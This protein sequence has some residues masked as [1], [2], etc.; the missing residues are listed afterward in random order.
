MSFKYEVEPVWQRK[1]NT[2]WYACLEMLLRYGGY[3][4]LADQHIYLLF[5]ERR[6]EEGKKIDY[7]LYTRHKQD[8]RVSLAE[9]Y[10]M[11]EEINK[12]IGARLK[13]AKEGTNL[14]PI[15]DFER[16]LR[17]YGPLLCGAHLINWRVGGAEDSQGHFVVVTGVETDKEDWVLYNDRLVEQYP[18]RCKYNLFKTLL[19]NK[20]VSKSFKQ[21]NEPA[22]DVSELR[23]NFMYIVKKV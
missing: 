10:A 9:L 2:C 3:E 20:T 22:G 15:G 4:K 19:F 23:Y 5:K 6:K 11:R 21:G 8:E 16:M 13:Y 14:G 1:S 12:V 7:L 18:V 17:G